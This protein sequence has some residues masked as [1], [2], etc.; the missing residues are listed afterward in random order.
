MNEEEIEGGKLSEREMLIAKA[1]AKIAVKELSEE[2]YKQV[3]KTVVQKA[4]IWL[5][6]A[7]VGVGAFKGWVSINIPPFSK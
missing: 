6:A 5:G 2:F 3:G 4:L 1:A 7:V